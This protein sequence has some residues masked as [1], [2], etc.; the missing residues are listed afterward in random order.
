[1]KRF[2]RW[3]KREL[4]TTSPV[5]LSAAKR[6]LF[7]TRRCFAPLSMTRGAEQLRE[8]KARC[9]GGSPGQSIVEMAVLV[10]FL[11]LMV[12][13]LWEMGQVFAAYISLINA[14]RE[15]AVFAALYPDLSDAGATP[16]DSQLYKDYLDRVKGEAVATGLDTHFLLVDRPIAPTID[17]NLPITVT[18]HYQLQ[19]FSSGMSMP[20]FGRMGLPSYYQINYSMV[21][22]I[23]EDR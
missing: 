14:S 20:L 1:M 18:V 9:T 5:T 17:V 7:A 16:L 21:M 8:L 22:P 4:V 10:P 2:D 23:R 12:L 19:T 15:G 3:L 6:L 11:V 13:A